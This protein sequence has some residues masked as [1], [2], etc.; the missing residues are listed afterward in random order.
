MA[1][2]APGIPTSELRRMTPA[3]SKLVRKEVQGHLDLEAKERI[4]HTKAVMKQVA[5]SGL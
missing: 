4:E 5:R 1:R 2:Y 3:E